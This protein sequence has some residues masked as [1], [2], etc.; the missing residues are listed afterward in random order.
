M[1]AELSSLDARMRATAAPDDLELSSVLSCRPRASSVAAGTVQAAGGLGGREEPGTHTL[2]GC[3]SA[4]Q[5][6]ML[7]VAEA[8]DVLVWCRDEVAHTGVARAPAEQPNSIVE[9]KHWSQRG[10]E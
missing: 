4:V 2:K 3:D 7:D 10:C 8:T 5:G 1:E 6:G 9:I